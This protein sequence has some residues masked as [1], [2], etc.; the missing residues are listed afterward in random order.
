MPKNN[1]TL[2]IF[3][4]ILHFTF[5]ECIILYMAIIVL[6]NLPMYKKLFGLAAALY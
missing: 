3:A 4:Y 1:N 5:S 6:K 2:P